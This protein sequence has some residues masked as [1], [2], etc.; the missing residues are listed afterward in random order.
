MART[1][2]YTSDPARDA[3]VVRS[4]RSGSLLC[5][6]LGSLYDC[7]SCCTLGCSWTLGGALG[8]GA[9]DGGAL[10]AGTS[11]VLLGRR[12]G[13]DAQVMAG[14]YAHCLHPRDVVR[15]MIVYMANAQHCF[16]SSLHSQIIK[17]AFRA[18]RFFRVKVFL[19]QKHCTLA[20]FY[21]GIHNHTSMDAP[22]WL[23]QH[24]HVSHGDGARSSPWQA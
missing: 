12:A 8:D 6:N 1:C 21:H 18:P 9:L 19:T 14:V 3:L 10:G 2:S 16:F 5:T 23:Q 15:H 22:P 7:L 17:M 20:T 4:S 24:P 11:E 13:D